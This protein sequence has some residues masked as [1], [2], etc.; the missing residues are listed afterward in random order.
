MGI[1]TINLDSDVP[2]NSD[3]AP[4]SIKLIIVLKIEYK[5]EFEYNSRL[6]GTLFTPLRSVIIHKRAF[7]VDLYI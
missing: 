4:P 5:S 3:L 7:S 6:Q 1:H 2:F